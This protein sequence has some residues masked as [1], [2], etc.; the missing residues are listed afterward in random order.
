MYVQSAQF[1]HHEGFMDVPADQK[2]NSAVTI[3]S[4][5][6]TRNDGKAARIT[7][8]VLSETDGG[9]KYTF[10]VVVVAQVSE[11]EGDGN[12]PI[13]EFVNTPAAISLV[14][15]F[16][17]QSLADLTVRGRFGSVW[18]NLINP[19]MFVHIESAGGPSGSSGPE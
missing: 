17:R 9:N 19:Q 7:M 12:L 16:L 10:D 4:K 3:E 5:T 18:L 14:Y 8:R 1:A 13:V 2:F 11:V 15:P 6:A